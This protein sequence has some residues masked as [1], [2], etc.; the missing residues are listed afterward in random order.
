MAIVIPVEFK[1]NLSQLVD[2]AND[3][4][5]SIGAD[6][7][8]VG[9][10]L[11]R[12]VSAPIVAVGTVAGVMASDVED[13]FARIEGLV[14]VDVTADMRQGVRDLAIEFGSSADEASGALFQITSAGLEGD[15]AMNTLAAS[16]QA[17]QVGLGDTAT[18]ADLATSAMNAYGSDTLSAVDA[19]DVLTAA[20]REGKLEPEEL[21][22]A[23]GSVLPIASNLGVGFDEVGAAMAGMSRTGT[24]AAEGATQLNAILSS[25][26]RPTA[27][28]EEA[29]EGMGLSSEGLRQQ[30]EDDGLLSVLQTLSGEFGGNEEA[31]ASVF[32]NIRALRGF[33]DL[34]GTSAEDNAAIF[35]ELENSTGALDTAFE[36]TSDTASFATKQ[37]F[38]EIKDVLLELG[39]AI[40]PIFV[41]ALKTLRDFIRPIIDRFRD[42]SPAGQRLIVIIGA[43]IAVIGPLVFLAGAL[44][45]A[46]AAISLP[47]LAVIA[48]IAALIA[49]GVLIVQN[50]DRIRA[51]AGRVWAAIDST[52]RGALG[53][54]RAFI[55]SVLAAVRRFFART[56]AAIT[57]G[58]S[59]AWKGIIR[60][61][62]GALRAVGR[63]I[64]GALRAIGR[65]FARTWRSITRGVSSA[66]RTIRRTVDR[67]IGAVADVIE[68]VLRAVGRFI[69][70]IVRGYLNTI[71]SIFTTIRS[72]VTNIVGGIRRAVRS[73]FEAIRRTVTNIINGIRGFIARVVGTIRRIFSTG[74]TDWRRIWI[75]F[76]VGLSD[77]VSRWIGIALDF[78]RRIP[79]NI[80]SAL[81]RLDNL[82]FDAGRNVIQGLIDGIKSLASAPV[83]AVKDIASSLPD[84]WPFSPA[85]E[86][87]LRE[88]PPEEAGANIIRLL[89]EGIRSEAET[90]QA[91]ARAAMVPV[92]AAPGSAAGGRAAA[93][94]PVPAAAGGGVNVSVNQNITGP[95][96]GNDRLREL[97]WTARFAVRQGLRNRRVEQQEI[98]L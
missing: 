48:A 47:V 31:M 56:W 27:E 3:Q 5:G 79:G 18:V 82:L 87:P 21:A 28:S 72:T 86:G 37:G 6:T 20:V 32:P 93:P 41:D 9:R 15:D 81:G 22:G 42:M 62:T 59:R 73:A 83:D 52:I 53:R 11:T 36:S 26:L 51:A 17:S 33:M 85:K 12:N 94:S 57:R 2:D 97:E 55:L 77:S 89:A 92:A 60:A 70:S 95:T 74:V 16:L 84:V 80:V 14:G 4:L 65:F 35:G 7:Q 58:V 78:I 67:A 54:A 34:M 69:S 8:Q 30:I 90:L 75:D 64:T 44:A 91:A 49:I 39:Q 46:M 43:V 24:G 50:W 25:L 68:S 23:M 88:F 19:T 45:T 38:A 10:N 98:N 1:A 61:V 63:A 66:W 76:L 29:L 71:R 96:T 13:N 40:L